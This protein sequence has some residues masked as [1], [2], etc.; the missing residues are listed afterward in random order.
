[1]SWYSYTSVLRIHLIEEP[2]VRH[3]DTVIGGALY[4]DP[5]LVQGRWLDLGRATGSDQPARLWT[6]VHV[7]RNLTGDTRSEG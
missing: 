2:G 5:P 1:M 6:S 4:K 7:T 3:E